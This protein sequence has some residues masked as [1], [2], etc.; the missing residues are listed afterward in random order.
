M[1]RFLRGRDLE[2]Y[3]GVRIFPHFFKIS[4]GVQSKMTLWCSGNLALK[5][6]TVKLRE[7][8][9]MFCAEPNSMK[10]GLSCMFLEF[11]AP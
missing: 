9:I 4:G 1:A 8:V 6:R 11:N 10:F 3:E 2:L 5:R 7:R